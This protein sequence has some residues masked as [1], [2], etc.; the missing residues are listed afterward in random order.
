VTA[1]DVQL[2]LA[3]PQAP[4]G[5][6]SPGSV[7][8]S[9]GRWIST[10]QLNSAVALNN[11]FPDLTGP[12]NAAGQVDYQC[13]FVFNTDDTDTIANV[14][15]WIPTSSVVGAVEWAVGADTTPVSAFNA[16]VTPQ[17]GFISSP[18]IAPTTVTNFI[19]SVTEP[20]EGAALSSLPPGHVAAFWIRRTAVNSPATTDPPAGFN[21]QVS[22]D[23]VT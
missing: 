5:F 7:Y 1:P 22:F 17:A 9:N 11:I 3:A 14:F 10:T 2:L 6:V 21:I 20:S 23:V 13:L 15:A 12:Q 16:T 8:A 18:T 4:S 19:D